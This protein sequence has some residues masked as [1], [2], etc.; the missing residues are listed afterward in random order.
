MP[1]LFGA[2]RFRGLRFPYRVL[3]DA[4]DGTGPAPLSLGLAGG[5]G[6]SIAL[7][8]TPAGAAHV[9]DAGNRAAPV[10]RITHTGIGA[11]TLD[12]VDIIYDI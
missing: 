3:G 10:L 5:A 12:K 9:L 2:T 11:L 4:V 7:D 6:P 8:P 1:A